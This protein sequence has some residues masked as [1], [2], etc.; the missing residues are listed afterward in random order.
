MFW[1]KSKEEKQKEE[2]K[3]IEETEKLIDIAVRFLS[4]PKIEDTSESA[5]KSFLRKKVYLVIIQGVE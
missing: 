4:N 3:K 1:G 5:K 2:Q